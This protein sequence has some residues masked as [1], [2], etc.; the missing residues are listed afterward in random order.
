MRPSDSVRAG[1]SLLFLLFQDHAS[2]QQVQDRQAEPILI[3]QDLNDYNRWFSG[4]P[5]SLVDRLRDVPTLLCHAFREM[6]SMGGQLL[7]VLYPYLCLVYLAYP[8]D[9]MLKALFGLLGFFDDCFVI[10]LLFIMYHKVVTQTGRLT[11]SGQEYEI[12]PIPLYI[13]SGQRHCDGQFAIYYFGLP[14]GPDK[15]PLYYGAAGSL[16]VRALD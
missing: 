15:S 1:N 11:A 7:D 8:L 5:R 14:W 9:F 3:L 12:N 16:V 4:Q 13:M 6:F 10:L 2:L